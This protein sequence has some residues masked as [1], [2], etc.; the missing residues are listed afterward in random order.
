MNWPMPVQRRRRGS[1]R[2]HT[3]VARRDLS[4]H[5]HLVEPAHVRAKQ[6]HLIDGLARAPLAQF[7]W[8]IRCADD[9]RRAAVVGF[10]DS[11]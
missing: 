3:G 8:A 7:G 6:I 9:H 1:Q 2:K 10:D 11:R 4:G 5:R